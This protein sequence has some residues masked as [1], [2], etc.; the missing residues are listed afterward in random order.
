MQIQRIFRF[1]HRLEYVRRH[2][3]CDAIVDLAG[4]GDHAAPAGVPRAARAHAQSMS[5]TS[6]AS[7]GCSARFRRAPLAGTHGCAT[8]ATACARAAR[9][10]E[11]VARGR[12][13]NS[14]HAAAQDETYAPDMTFGDHIVLD[15]GALHLGGCT[16]LTLARQRVL[17]HPDGRFFSGDSLV[18]G[19]AVVTRACA[20]AAPPSPWTGPCRFCAHCRRSLRSI[21]PRPVRYVAW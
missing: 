10:A 4:Q 20:G 15:W 19:N 9:S 18:P 8:P 7:A 2:A 1:R 17:P 12:R 16:R 3:G 6:P 14:A 13:A 21:R 11:R 5:S